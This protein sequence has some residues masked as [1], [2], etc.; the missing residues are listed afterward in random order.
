MKTKTTITGLAVVL[1]ALITLSGCDAILE[2]FYPEFGDREGSNTIAL[3][4][5]I[6]IPG[7]DIGDPQI[8]AVVEDAWDKEADPVQIQFV[9]PTSY[10]DENGNLVLT[11]Y[12]EFYGLEGTEADPRD[13]QVFVWLEQNGDDRPNWEEPQ[14][15]AFWQPYPD[16]QEWK[17]DVIWF[18]NE[19]GTYIEA[20]A[21]AG[22][23]QA[24]VNHQF[25]VMGTM[26]IDTNNTPRTQTYTIQP[27]NPNLSIQEYSW[28]LFNEDNLY[29]K[30]TEGYSSVGGA[31]SA[32]LT[33]SFTGLPDALYWLEISLGYTNGEWRFARYPVVVGPEVTTFGATYDLQVWIFNLDLQP[34]YVPNNESYEARVRIYHPGGTFDEYPINVYP[35]N[36]E[37][38]LF[39]PGLVYNRSAWIDGNGLDWV[40]ITIDTKKGDGFGPGDWMVEMPI[41]LTTTDGGYKAFYLDSWD[42]RPIF[43]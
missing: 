19:Y 7:G 12:I 10:W 1:V 6:A 33:V 41:G 35:T 20:Y 43:P 11:A 4:V 21:F 30:V 32:Q 28:G 13:Y 2:A 17:E 39:V 16:D 37:V 34:T 40:S 18:P 27:V 26:M 15:Y 22:L 29:A 42:L 8:A 9:W 3:Q 24:A 25:N 36:G 38:S 5:E 14:T 23:N 31:A